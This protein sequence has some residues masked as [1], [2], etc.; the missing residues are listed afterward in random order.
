MTVI[1][2]TGAGSLKRWTAS[3]TMAPLATSSSMAL[4]SDA[5]IGVRFMP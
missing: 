4:A 3:Q 1:S 5:R 2:A